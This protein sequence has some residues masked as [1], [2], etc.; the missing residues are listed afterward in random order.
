MFELL[1]A[2]TAITIIPTLIG[3]LLPIRYTNWATR[4]LWAILMIG[5]VMTLIYSPA[6]YVVIILAAIAGLIR[7]IIYS[8]TQRSHIELTVPMIIGIVMVLVLLAITWS[9]VINNPLDPGVAWDAA[10][11]WFTKAK[12]IYYWRDFDF[13]AMINYPNVGPNLWAY[14]MS[15]SGLQEHLGRLMFPAIYA[16][17]FA[18]VLRNVRDRIY[19]LVLLLPLLACGIYLLLPGTVNGYQDIFLG[20]VA[21]TG[22]YLL[23]NVIFNSYTDPKQ[24]RWDFIL[25]L[26][27]CGAISLIKNEGLVFGII[28]VLCFVSVYLVQHFKMIKS[29]LRRNWKWG[30][31]GAVL[32]VAPIVVWN[33]VLVYHNVNLAHVQGNYFTISGILDIPNKLNNFPLI[34]DYVSG[35][36]DRLTMII[37]LAIVT[38]VAATF[39]DFNWKKLFANL[40]LWAV[41]VVHTLFII[42]TFLATTADISWHLGT[43]ANRLMMQHDLFYALILV[44]NSTLLANMVFDGKKGLARLLYPVF[45]AVKEKGGVKSHN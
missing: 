38:T 16:F 41:V 37:L 17:W 13:I 21:A 26:F 35:Y 2:I 43:A 19:S 3:F 1:G 25:G 20:I 33:I 8:R 28:I 29:E 4:W 18:L 7:L 12:H 44:V 27:F 36:T 15:F 40:F 30:L 42:F 23:Y 32:I 9:D 11:I 39:V 10:V 24:K 14:V 22:G 6:A 31:L 34:W 5:I 45:V